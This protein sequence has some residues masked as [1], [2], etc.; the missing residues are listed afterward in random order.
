[1]RSALVHDNVTLVSDS[2]SPRASHSR[3]EQLRLRE[4]KTMLSGQVL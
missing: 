4:V 1:M 3:D 2:A